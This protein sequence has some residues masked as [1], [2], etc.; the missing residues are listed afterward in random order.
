VRTQHFGFD[1]GVCCVQELYV[2]DN[3]LESLPTL[4]RLASLTVMDVEGNRLDVRFYV[5][6]CC[7]GVLPV[8]NR[9]AGL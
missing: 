2:A 8:S 7:L 6:L 4:S 1:D 3:L 9:D 5:V